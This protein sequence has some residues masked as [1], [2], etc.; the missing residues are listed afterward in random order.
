KKG[1][2]RILRAWASART[3]GE[4]L[5]VAGVQGTDADGVRYA[6][7]LPAVEYRQLLRRSRTYVSAPRWEDFGM[8][9]MEALA[10]GCVLVCMYG[11][12]PYVALPLARA[13]DARLVV[14]D[15]DAFT[16]AI[17]TALDDPA[18]DYARRAEP[19]VAPYST[20]AV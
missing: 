12:G 15:E 3:A 16:R 13:L 14:R 7:R 2:D 10:D 4:E 20:P 6:G 1:L 19:L 18:A 17:R 8:A 5:V 11:R 9:Q